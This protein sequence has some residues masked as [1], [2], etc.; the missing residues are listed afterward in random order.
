MEKNFSSS[1][2]TYF[3][4]YIINNQND[5]SIDI[6]VND[7]KNHPSDYDKNRNYKNKYYK[8]KKKYLKLKQKLI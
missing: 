4:K 5:Y 2:N 7:S 8:Y 1:N 3:N 6:Y